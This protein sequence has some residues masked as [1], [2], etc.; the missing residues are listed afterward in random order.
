MSKLI[1]GK[2]I[3]V[4]DFPAEYRGLTEKLAFVLNPF[5][6]KLTNAFNKDIT[7]TE[8]LSME[9]KTFTV[10]VDVNGIPKS[11]TAFTTTLGRLT[12][13]LVVNHQDLSTGIFSNLTGAP[14]CTFSQSNNIV[15]LDHIAGLDLDKKYSLTLLL[16]G[17]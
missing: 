10:E 11:T 2:R 9:Y 8:N 5:M 16:L 1:G 15:T 17:K 7:V 4:E 14:Y 6:E 13:L 12:G 3:L